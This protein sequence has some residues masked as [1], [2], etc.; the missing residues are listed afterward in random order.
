MQQI[1]KAKCRRGPKQPT[2]VPKDVDDGIYYPRNETMLVCYFMQIHAP[3]INWKPPNLRSI[4]TGE[5]ITLHI[6]E[7]SDSDDSIF[8]DTEDIITQLH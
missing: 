1:R 6:F 7:D 8:S 3:R 2:K 5:Q 4:R